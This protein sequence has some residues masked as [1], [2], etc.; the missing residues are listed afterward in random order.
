[1]SRQGPGKLQLEQAVERRV[2]DSAA[3]EVVVSLGGSD[4]LGQRAPGRAEIDQVPGQVVAAIQDIS[5]LEPGPRS[6]QAERQVVV[7]GV[8]PVVDKPRVNESHHAGELAALPPI[9]FHGQLTELQGTVTVIAQ[10]AG[11][12]GEHGIDAGRQRRLAMAQDKA[13]VFG[14]EE[15]K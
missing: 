5:C 4:D 13:H 11:D 15:R 9:Q 6:V 14:R 8:L 10:Q 3:D 1:M 7:Q 12:D 2:A